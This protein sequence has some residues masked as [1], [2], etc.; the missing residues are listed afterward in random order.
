M[1]K[2]L[3][4]MS[5]CIHRISDLMLSM[6]KTNGLQA[7]NYKTSIWTYDQNSTLTALKH[8]LQQRSTP[9]PKPICYR[10]G[11]LIIQT[12]LMGPLT[13]HLPTPI[14][15]INQLHQSRSCPQAIP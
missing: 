9:L 10:A 4:M 7:I 8:F 15:I 13:H 12:S 5:V 14:R 2:P 3:I 11:Y 1:T 6:T